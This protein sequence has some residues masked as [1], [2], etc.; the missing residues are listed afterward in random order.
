MAKVTSQGVKLSEYVTYTISGRSELNAGS[1]IPF[2]TIYA[3]TDTNTCFK[4]DNNDILFLK[5]CTVLVNFCIPMLCYSTR[6]WI[7]LK[8]N[9]TIIA[10]SILTSTNP[11]YETSSI[12]PKMLKMKC[13][14]RLNIIIQ[15]FEP[16]GGYATIGYY[17]SNTDGVYLTIQKID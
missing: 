13:G 5:D 4:L 9:N 11:S 16:S 10:T 15:N 12:S 2:S 14:D 7:Q 6:T 1:K 3:K 8:L 17:L